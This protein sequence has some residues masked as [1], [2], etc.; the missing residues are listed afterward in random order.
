MQGQAVESL[1]VKSTSSHTGFVTFAGTSG[2][3]I[4]LPQGA[5]APADERALGFV[6][7]YGA[8][9]GLADRSQVR[10][11]RAPRTDELGFEPVRF[12]Q[13]HQGVPVTAAEFI[14]HM[15][16]A[17]VTAAN[18]AVVRDL[19]ASVVPTITAAGA[20]D[21]ARELIAKYKAA[22][23]PGA[24][25]SEPRLEIFN[26]GVLQAGEYPSRLAW[27]VEATDVALREYI[28]VD[29]QTGAILMHFSQL[30][31]ALSRKIY[32]ANGGTALPGTLLR[33]EGG[34]ATGD[35]DADNAY[36]YAGITYNYYF[37]NHG[38]D[39]YDNAGAMLV[40][41]VHACTAN[42]PCPM[43]NAFWN[44]QQMVYGNSYAS[45][46]D[47][48]GHE[49]THAV[50][51]RSAGLLYYNQSGALNE[52]FSDI[53]GETIDQL[54]S[55]GGGNDT[56]NARWLIGE[57][58]PI[59]AIRHMMNPSLFN[60]PAKVI[61]GNYKCVEDAWTNDFGDMGG[62]HSNSGIPNHAYALMV[63][64]GSYNGQTI[65]GIGLTKAAKIE[66]R[67]LTTYLTSGSGFLDAFNALNQ[68]CT[69]LIGTA[70][71]TASDCTQVNKALVAVQMNNATPP[72]PGTVAAPVLCPNGPGYAPTF[73]FQDGFEQNTGSWA[74]TAM[75]G[76]VWLPSDTGLAKTGTHMASGSDPA[77]TSDAKLAMTFAVLIPNGGR[78]YFDTAYEFE[79]DGV[80]GTF[81]DGGKIEYST[82]AGATWFDAGSLIDGGRGYSGTIS[83]TDGSIIAG[84]QAFVG[85][86]YGYTGTR[87]NLASLAGQS[88]RFRFRVVSDANVGS[89]GWVVDNFGIYA[90]SVASAPVVT[91]HP[92]T[93]TVVPG[94]VVAFSSMATGSPNPTVQWQ[95]S[96]NGAAGPFTNIPGATSTTYSFAAALTDS[97]KAFRAVFTNSA[98]TAT[99]N[100]ATLTVT[101]PAQWGSL[102]V[103]LSGLPAGTSA[104]LVITG[105]NNYSSARNVMTG[106]GFT[107]SDLAVGTYTVTAPAVVAGG[108]YTAAPKTATVTSNATATINI[109][110]SKVGGS[111]QADFDGD[112]KSEMVAYKPWGVWAML[113]STSGY[114]ASTTATVGGPG[115]V[116]VPG[117]YDG[118]GKIDP[119][120][121]TPAT[122]QWLALKSS[123]SYATTFSLTWGGGVPAPGDYDGDGKTDPAVY[124]EATA[125]WQI[126][127]SSSGYTVPLTV[128]W[129]GV[130][131]TPVPGSDFDGDGKA[132]IAVYSESASSWYVLKSTTN[133]TTTLNIP[134]G[135]RGY[136]LV[137][138]DYDGD[139]K[140][141]LGL[142]QRATGNWYV[143]KSGAGYTTTLSQAWGGL[144][145]DPVPGDYDGDGKTDLGLF[146]RATGT[147][148]ILKS[149]AGYTTSFNVPGWGGSGDTVMPGAIR[150]GRDDMRRATDVD[151]DGKADITVYNAS[152]AAWYTLTS[153]STYNSAA[154]RAWGGAGYAIAPG[155]FDGDGKL[156][157]GAY[158]A[159]TGT[160]VVLL[161]GAGF[162]TSISKV[163]GGALFTPLVG[164]YDGDGK[165]DLAVYN[166]TTAQWLVLTSSSTFM[167]TTAVAWGGPGFTPVPGDYDGDGKTD[168]G[169]YQ[170]SSGTWYVLLAASNFTTSM[171]RTVGGAAWS[172]TPGDYDGDGKVDFV[173][174]NGTTGQWYG[175]KSSTSYTTTVN[176]MWGGPGYTP[177]QGDY[178][179]DG[180][181]DLAVYTAAGV[182]SILQSS[183]NYT[184]TI[185]KTW[186]SGAAYAPVP[187]YQ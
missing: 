87:L 6:D 176:V 141:D 20:Q 157:Y 161:S 146:Q 142:Y 21:A 59:G 36:L 40:S 57:D 56:V 109:A 182:W 52:S 64:G 107:Q 83:P 28:W 116:P 170:P 152:V 25:F 158:Q 159:S 134:W 13:V 121:Y 42:Q 102:A 39:S 186:G 103:N 111:V 180:K 187:K 113:K 123:T 183:S 90:C 138:G 67:A 122:G 144:A 74:P 117:D 147:W 163:L 135:G 29:A 89:L 101:P 30:A 133:Y 18:G 1:A 115:T 96:V 22:A 26:K 80:N 105:P 166:G 16:G 94:T 43:Q 173:V 48:V 69:D 70:G 15:N 104:V 179:G 119:A 153:T 11:A 140:T 81:Y 38:R 44:G 86:T 171:T 3:G 169:V 129:G 55:T 79:N 155:D 108:T 82:N 46:D 162:T 53:F 97:G 8:Q 175:L 145:Y 23:A 66:Y 167:A 50:T 75:G 172:P 118:D 78:A 177:V 165:S 131:Y 114:T 49:L 112:G 184:T 168:I 5:N 27:F 65:A 100:A 63:D 124:V 127:K 24:Q 77:A 61:D 148:Y 143:L 98:G 85:S 150:V 178:D 41:T 58:L 160:F 14:V 32:T 12:Q 84:Q 19:P 110:Y 54:S 10:L 132:D 9:F 137:P 34:A 154:N 4:L 76:G 71:I 181:V 130:G 128:S 91:S 88:V 149:N 164:D 2:R 93:T 73:W 31:H 45:A 151:G 62:V 125:Q 139:G 33:T 7:L 37:T 60:D 47:V 136:T 51:E 92:M 106:T 99:S 17:R 68:A 95:V 174:Y 126:L 120:A 72:C 156:D 185:S 35:A